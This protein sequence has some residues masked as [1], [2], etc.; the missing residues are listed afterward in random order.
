MLKPGYSRCL[1]S[2]QRQ[3]KTVGTAITGCLALRYIQLN[4]NAACLLVYHSKA[5]TYH[6]TSL[7]GTA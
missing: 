4:E 7:L 1:A 5:Q 2:V 3:A 6:Y